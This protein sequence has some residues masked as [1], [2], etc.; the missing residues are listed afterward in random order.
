MSLRSAWSALNDE[1][2]S[3]FDKV[4]SIV[5]SVSFALPSLISAISTLNKNGGILGSINVIRELD[6]AGAEKLRDKFSSTGSTVKDA[7]T[8]AKE[9]GV[10]NLIWNENDK[11]NKGKEIKEILEK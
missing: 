4:L 6:Q 1:D 3:F 2:M 5:S 9:T 7:F 10:K 11:S 8:S